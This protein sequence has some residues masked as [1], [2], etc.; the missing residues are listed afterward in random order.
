MFTQPLYGYAHSQRKN[1]MNKSDLDHIQRSRILKAGEK[2]MTH[3]DNMVRSINL[4]YPEL[5]KNIEMPPDLIN[6]PERNYNSYD[7]QF[8]NMFN[9]IN[10]K[11]NILA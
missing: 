7:S 8:F 11:R 6:D 1:A 4:K 2:I 9:M 10:N 3:V 5:A